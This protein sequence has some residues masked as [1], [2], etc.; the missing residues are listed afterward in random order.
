MNGLSGK[1]HFSH[2]CVE[3]TDSLDYVEPETISFEAW[4][5]NRVCCAVHAQ[6]MQ[7]I[8]AKS[9]TS[10]YYD[11]RTGFSSNNLSPG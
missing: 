7:S 6:M 8:P 2:D 9:V 5:S 10:G 1:A 3:A 4:V 11:C